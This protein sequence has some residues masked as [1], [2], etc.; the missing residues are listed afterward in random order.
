MLTLYH[1]AGARSF[2]ILWAL[3]E[4]GAAY[5]LKLMAFPPRFREPEYLALNPMGTVPT[6]VDGD[7]MLSESVAGCA[8]VAARHGPTPLVLT[9]DEPDFGAYL[10]FLHMGEATL[11]FPQTIYLRYAVFEPEERRLPQAA[12]DYTQWFFSRLKGAAKLLG[13]KDYLASDRFTLADISVGY[14]LVLA[15]QLGFSDGFPPAFAAYLARLK[16]REAF[17]RAMEIE[18]PEGSPKPAVP[19]R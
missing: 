13:D 18:R 12:A 19:P 7:T 6:L 3:E 16:S 1:C 5:D 14:A 4:L 9:P 17:Q 15:E 11:T 8:Y 2:R 10:N